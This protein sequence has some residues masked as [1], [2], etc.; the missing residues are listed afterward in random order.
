MD[1]VD[2]EREKKVMEKKGCSWTITMNFNFSYI[3]LRVKIT[4]TPAPHAV[5]QGKSHIWFFDDNKYTKARYLLFNDST[6][7]KSDCVIK[8][9]LRG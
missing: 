3:A 5:L 7:K 8:E 9:I 6:S 4:A 2:T 1:A